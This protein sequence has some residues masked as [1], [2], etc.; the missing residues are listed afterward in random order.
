MGTAAVPISRRKATRIG[1]SVA[2]PWVSEGMPVRPVGRSGSIP[3]VAGS[4]TGPPGRTCF[5]VL[6]QGSA[7]L[8]PFD[9][10][11]AGSG[12]FS[13]RPSGTGTEPSPVFH[14]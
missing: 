1:W 4:P 9:K 3:D 2:K 14:F 12:L 5:H 7:T 11:R 10:L 8:R 13:L 6:T